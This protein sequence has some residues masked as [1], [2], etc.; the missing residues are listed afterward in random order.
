MFLEFLYRFSKYLLPLKLAC[1][2]INCVEFVI[3]CG[4]FKQQWDSLS[5][6]D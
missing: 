6:F 5:F 4:C 3:F 2:L 1:L